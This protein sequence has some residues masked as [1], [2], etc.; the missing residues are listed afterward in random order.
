MIER[1]MERFDLHPIKL[2]GD[3]A[4]GLADM[5]GWLRPLGPC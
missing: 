4:Y 5:L 2:M 3:S 1:S